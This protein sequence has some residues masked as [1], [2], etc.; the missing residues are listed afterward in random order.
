MPRANRRPSVP[1]YPSGKIRPEAVVPRQEK[2]EDAM[3]TVKAARARRGYVDVKSNLDGRPGFALGRLNLNNVIDGDMLEAGKRYA[4]DLHRYYTL[5]GYATPTP[6]AL[7]M[8]AVGGR[9]VRADPDEEDV[10]KARRKVA[11]ISSAIRYA[12]GNSM[13]KQSFAMVAVRN[14]CILDDDPTHWPDHMMTGLQVG[15]RALV[16]YYGI[17]ER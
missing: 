16:R 14:V 3:A 5:E 12:A 10:A 17:G 2:P 6:K 7:E 11:E 15:L 4:L 8:G 9:P 1:R 13:S